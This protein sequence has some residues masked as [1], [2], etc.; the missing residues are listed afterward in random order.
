MGSQ[1]ENC[2]PNCPYFPAKIDHLHLKQRILEKNTKITISGRSLRFS[3]RNSLSLQI[4]KGPP[5]VQSEINLG[6]N[7]G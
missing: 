6:D 1:G 5:T 7:D 2:L 3:G 4:V